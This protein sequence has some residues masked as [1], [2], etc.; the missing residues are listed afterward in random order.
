M[1]SSL[2]RFLL[3]RRCRR[4]RWPRSPLPERKIINFELLYYAQTFQTCQVNPVLRRGQREGDGLVLGDG[5]E[6]Q[7]IFRAALEKKTAILEFVHF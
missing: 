6:L 2:L 7:G 5:L 1:Q 4:C 3:R